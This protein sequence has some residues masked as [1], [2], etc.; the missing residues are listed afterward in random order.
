[1]ENQIDN[2]E[3]KKDRE[4]VEEV[5]RVT[6]TKATDEVLT[7]IVDKINDGFEGGR[8]NR[9]QAISW[10]L[11]KFSEDMA[12]ATVREIRANHFDEI[13]LLSA[14]LKKAKKTGAIPPELREMLQRQFG[15]DDTPSKKTRGRLTRD[16]IND[17]N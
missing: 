7:K 4:Q 14:M 16:F 8:I 12:E 3:E 13:A 15:L 17:E 10:I 9:S 2:T 11:A 1:M 5:Y 6:V